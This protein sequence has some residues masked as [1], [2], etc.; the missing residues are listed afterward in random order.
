MTEAQTKK[1]RI[2]QANGN[3]GARFKADKGLWEW[4]HTLA[5]GRRVSA[6][7]KTQLE[8][9]RRCLEKVRQ[10]EAGLVIADQRQTVK[11]YLAWWLETIVE[12]KLAPKTTETYRDMVRLHLE[13]ELG[14]HELRKLTAQHVDAMLKRKEKAGL[15]PRSLGM[16]RAVLRAALGV[17][18]KKRILERNV[19]TFSEPPRQ[20]ATPRRVLTPEEG[21]KLLA[22]IEG[23]KGERLKALYRLALLTG[24]RQAEIIGLRWVDVDLSGKTLRVEQSIQR[25]G[26]QEYVQAPKTARSK[27]TLALP[28]SLVQALQAHQDAQAFERKQAGATWQETGLV[29]TGPAGA[30]VNPRTLVKSFKRHLTAAGLPETVRFY[31]MR[32]AAASLLIAEG[33]PLPA[34]SAM[35]GHSLTSTTLN[36]YSHVLPGAERVTA[37]TM[38]RLLG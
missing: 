20:T 31:D 7:A 32:H 19:A 22:V 17:A 14:R 26:K 11:A 25:I 16:M 27:R 1:R 35:L 29:F 23:T 37:D 36:T 18:V 8:A 6:T 38:E 34:V 9:K 2:K 4:R 28:D 13:P 12:P 3:G 21:R 15:S 33:V 24:M 5:D 30:A 10:A